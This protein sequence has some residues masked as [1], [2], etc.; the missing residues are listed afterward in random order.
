MYHPAEEKQWQAED[1]VSNLASIVRTLEEV[2]NDGCD[3]TEVDWLISHLNLVREKISEE[4]V[5]V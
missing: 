2:K 3:V 4:V 1:A 5:Y